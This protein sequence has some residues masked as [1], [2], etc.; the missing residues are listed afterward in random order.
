MVKLSRWIAGNVC[1]LK[2]SKERCLSVVFYISP[3]RIF[4]SLPEYPTATL[5][6]AFHFERNTFAL[7]CD[8]CKA[9]IKQLTFQF[10]PNFRSRLIVPIQMPN[11]GETFVETILE[12]VTIVTPPQLQHISA[13]SGLNRTKL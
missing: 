9:C 8:N 4:Q 13:F 2:I 10:G 3:F 7:P 6:W 1:F 11:V 5:F 12:L